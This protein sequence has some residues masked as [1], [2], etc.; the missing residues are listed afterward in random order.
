MMP[1]RIVDAL[2]F[3]DIDVE[4]CEL[5]ALAGFLELAFD[6]VA[7][8]HPVR[9][10]GQRI[11]MREMRDLLV[12]TPAFGHVVDDVYDIPAFAGLILNPDAL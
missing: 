2:E 11:V 3:V 4:Q 5:L 10:I 9:Q 12:G 1:E 7:E 8:Q 6:L